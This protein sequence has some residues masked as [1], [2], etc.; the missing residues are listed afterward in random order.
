MFL[1]IDWVGV[2]PENGRKLLLSIAFVG[3][4]DHATLQTKSWTRQAVSLLAAVVLVL[5]L[6][7]TQG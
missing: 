1:G 3:R 2:S 6:L 7:S 4:T 5:G